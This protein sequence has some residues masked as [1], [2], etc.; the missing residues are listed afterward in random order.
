MRIVK[1]MNTANDDDVKK[2]VRWN[3]MRILKFNQCTRGYQAM[4]NQN[5]LT[6]DCTEIS[7]KVR[8]CNT[9]FAV[10]ILGVCFFN[11]NYWT[12]LD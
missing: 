6:V 8:S 3:L 9:S 2:T 10:C 1:R 12:Y 11:Y 4:Q 7:Y 5:K